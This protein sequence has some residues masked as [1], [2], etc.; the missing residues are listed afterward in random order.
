MIHKISPRLH[1][2][3][4]ELFSLSTPTS[5]PSGTSSPRGFIRPLHRP[6]PRR[7]VIVCFH[8]PHRLPALP[9][10]LIHRFLLVA[11]TSTRI[12]TPIITHI[13]WRPQAL[14]LLQHLEG[15]RA[16]KSVSGEVWPFGLLHSTSGV[17][18]NSSYSTRPCNVGKIE[19]RM[20]SHIS[21]Y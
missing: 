13:I 9:A 2:L 5:P 7:A 3:R 17:S 1:T 21:D 6:S 14:F 12:S 19:I 18:L 11:R 8:A 10:M 16:G 15:S 20:S 4:L